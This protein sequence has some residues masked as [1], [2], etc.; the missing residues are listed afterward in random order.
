MIQ[1][2]DREPDNLM[3]KWIADALT[4]EMVELSIPKI[5]RHNA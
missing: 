5:D 2:I 1:V 3:I 4:R